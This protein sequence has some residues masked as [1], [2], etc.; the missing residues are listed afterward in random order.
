MLSLQNN[1]P[2]CHP[3]SFLRELAGE[4]VLLIRLFLGGETVKV[5]GISPRNK[6]MQM[7]ERGCHREKV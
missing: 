4:W 3:T 2:V 7:T 5:D 1:S 6:I